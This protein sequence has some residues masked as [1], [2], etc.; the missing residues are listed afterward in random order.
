MSLD[1][2]SKLSWL[3]ASSRARFN[4]IR[5]HEPV[6]RTN[7]C[8]AVIALVT[9]TLVA[10][11]EGWGLGGTVRSWRCQ[12]V[13]S[14]VPMASKCQNID[15]RRPLSAAAGAQM[16]QDQFKIK[17]LEGGCGV[18]LGVRLTPV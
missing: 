7:E 9:R 6:T 5:K 18:G 16:Q 15:T 3:R 13:R 14:S 12:A 17:M 8:H 2:L 10:K 11:A 4:S 1:R